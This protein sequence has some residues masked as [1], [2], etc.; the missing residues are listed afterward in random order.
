MNISCDLRL[1]SLVSTLFTS[2][3]IINIYN[4]VMIGLLISYNYVHNHH[5]KE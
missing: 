2:T 3:Q 4:S 1:Y 5:E